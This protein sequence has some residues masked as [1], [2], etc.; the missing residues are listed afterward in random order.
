MLEILAKRK[1]AGN[2]LNPELSAIDSTGLIPVILQ[3]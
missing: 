2:S 3:K 1:P